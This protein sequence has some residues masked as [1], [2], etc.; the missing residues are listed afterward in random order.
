MESGADGAAAAEGGGGGGGGEGAPEVALHSGSTSAVHPW[1][2]SMIN[3][4]QPIKFQSFEQA[5]RKEQ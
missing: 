5:Q 1:L 3:Y 2:S 4:A